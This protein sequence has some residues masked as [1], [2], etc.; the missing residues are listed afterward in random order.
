MKEIPYTNDLKSYELRHWIAHKDK[1]YSRDRGNSM[2]LLFRDLTFDFN[3]IAVDVGCG[4]HCGVF[5]SLSFAK[6]IA[7]DP[8]W[9]LYKKNKVAILKEEVQTICSDAQS[10]QLNSKADLIFS[11][12][13]LDH[14]GNLQKSIDNI[15]GNLKLNGSFL[16]H[17]HMRTEAQLNA[18]HKMLI[19]EAEIDSILSNYS[20]VSK[21]IEEVCPLDKKPYK[22]YI[23]HVKHK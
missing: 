20:I 15:M 3:S 11:F 6:M 1:D 23:T 22:S 13:S 4:P 12:N 8:L 21:R 17:L 19:K 2:S 16:M 10:F 5:N 9:D 7:V 18:G 14:S